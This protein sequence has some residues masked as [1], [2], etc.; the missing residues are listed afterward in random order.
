MI[1]SGQLLQ[2]PDTME[3]S[4]RESSIAKL[5][6]TVDTLIDGPSFNPKPQ[7]YDPSCATKTVSVSW[8]LAIASI[9]IILHQQNQKDAR[10]RD[11]IGFRRDIETTNLVPTIRSK[12]LLT[13]MLTGSSLSI[14]FRTSSSTIPRIPPL[15]QSVC[16]N[17]FETTARRTYPSKDKTRTPA[18]GGMNLTKQGE[19]FR[20]CA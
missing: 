8:L 16:D 3:L 20:S 15:F 17:S 14:A 6:K 19:I 7:C 5:L 11:S 18:S 10:L 1:E 9:E 4:R 13:G 12:K 2:T